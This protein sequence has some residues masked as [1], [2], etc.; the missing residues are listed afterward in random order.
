MKKLIQIIKFILKKF[1]SLLVFICLYIVLYVPFR[2]LIDFAT[3][4]DGNIIMW[5]CVFPS[6]II[7][8]IIINYTSITSRILNLFSNINL[9]RPLIKGDS[10]ITPIPNNSNKNNMLDK[11][12][13][14]YLS[15]KWRRLVRTISILYLVFWII[16][17]CMGIIQNDN[18]RFD[19]SGIALIMILFPPLLSYIIEPFVKNMK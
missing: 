14:G 8:F 13:F 5:F 17:C 2:Y 6:A 3:A 19:S 10:K 9:K 16:F 1:I 15:L 7:A 18:F 11:F 12:F 4:E